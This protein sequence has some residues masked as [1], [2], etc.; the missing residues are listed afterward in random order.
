MLG[1]YLYLITIIIVA[2]G[3]VF[4]EW[5]I[6]FNYLKKY[7][8]QI[9]FLGVVGLLI[10]PFLEGSALKAKDYSYFPET[11]FNK[12]FLGAEVET[13]LFSFLVSIA[14]SSAV[15]LGTHISKSKNI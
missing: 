11:T 6:E 14:I 12:L 5:L 3:T 1:N 13:Y 2:G 4:I 15:I 9:L 7:T 8:K 10:T